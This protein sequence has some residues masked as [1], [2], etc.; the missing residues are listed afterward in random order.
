MQVFPLLIRYNVLLEVSWN[1][2]TEN[3][4][5]ALAIPTQRGYLLCH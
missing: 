4:L 3:S 5:Q 2:Q 1:K